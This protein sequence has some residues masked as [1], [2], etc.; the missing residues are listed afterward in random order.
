[1]K[2]IRCRSGKTIAYGAR[3]ICVMCGFTWHT[4]SANES[5]ELMRRRE[6]LK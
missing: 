1:M 4:N 6:C 3:W 2:C 5:E